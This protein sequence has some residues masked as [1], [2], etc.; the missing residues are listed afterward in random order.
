[1][2]TQPSCVKC[3]I[4]LGFIDQPAAYFYEGFAYCPRHIDKTMK[5]TV[6]AAQLESEMRNRYEQLI[7]VLPYNK[8]FSYET[9]NNEKKKYE[10]IAAQYGFKSLVD[11]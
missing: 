5:C 4:K 11:Y 9:Y 3:S 7:K 6:D 8:N 10:R 1:M 2:L